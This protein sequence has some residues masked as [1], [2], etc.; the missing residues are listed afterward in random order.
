MTATL[1]CYFIF[2]LQNG[3]SPYMTTGEFKCYN[4]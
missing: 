3:M 1:S 4:P 2:F